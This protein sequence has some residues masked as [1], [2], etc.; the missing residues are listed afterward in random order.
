MSVVLHSMKTDAIISLIAANL[1][2]LKI[3]G[4]SLPLQFAGVHYKVDSRY[5]VV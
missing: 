3:L 4:S 2:T 5:R 1:Y